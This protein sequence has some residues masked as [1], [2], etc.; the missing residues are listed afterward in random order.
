[1]NSLKNKQQR[2][3]TWNKIAFLRVLF[4]TFRIYVVCFLHPFPGVALSFSSTPNTFFFPFCFQP[5][6]TDIPTHRQATLPNVVSAFSITLLF[7]I[8]WWW[9]R[10]WVEQTWS[11]PVEWLPDW[12]Q[13]LS[14]DQL[15]V[16][17]SRCQL[18]SRLINANVSRMGPG[19]NGHG[20]VVIQKRYLF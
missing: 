13:C 20:G 18:Q 12:L 19:G 15:F 14:R 11:V 6:D 10:S 5:F 3:T 4:L 7:F 8:P 17:V 1:M 9:G 2:L 16:P